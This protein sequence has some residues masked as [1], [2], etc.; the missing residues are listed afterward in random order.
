MSKLGGLSGQNISL[1]WVPDCIRVLERVRSN[2]YGPLAWHVL[3]LCDPLCFV[4]GLRE[5]DG[6]FFHVFAS[7][8]LDARVLSPSTFDWNLVLFCVCFKLE[9]IAFVSAFTLEF[10]TAN[11]EKWTP[12]STRNDS[13]SRILPS[14]ASR[15][16]TMPVETFYKYW[17][18]VWKWGC[19]GSSHE[20]YNT[21]SPIL[22]F[23]LIQAIRPTNHDSKNRFWI[24]MGFGYVVHSTLALKTLTKQPLNNVH[25]TIIQCHHVGL[26][27]DILLTNFFFWTYID[28]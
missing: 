21:Y 11:S 12:K 15:H 8:V 3:P 24:H 13:H 14:N 17:I 7:G 27:N 26:M 4:D 10:S 2:T 20:F 28:I 5:P 25:D 1:L 16:V 6:D 18:S 19:D 9:T 23:F 22:C